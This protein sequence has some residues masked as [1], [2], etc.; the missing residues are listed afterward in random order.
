MNT[1]EA[2]ASGNPMAEGDVVGDIG[3]LEQREKFIA[4]MQG[5]VIKAGRLAESSA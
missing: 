1:D 4:V 3:L 5:G 2:S